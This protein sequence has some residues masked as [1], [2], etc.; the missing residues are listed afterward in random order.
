MTTIVLEAPLAIHLIIV[1]IMLILSNLVWA[2]TFN[3]NIPLIHEKGY[4]PVF[5]I[6]FFQGMALFVVW[7][8]LP[9]AA[10]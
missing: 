1:W 9:T 5:Y 7:M 3:M 6:A 4:T 10:G 8:L 2:V